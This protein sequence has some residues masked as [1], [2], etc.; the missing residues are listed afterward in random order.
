MSISILYITDQQ[1]LNDYIFNLRA[2]LQSIDE[3][4]QCK[5]VAV[6]TETTGL[7]PH[8]D[9]I[10]LIQLYVKGFS[11][12]LVIDCFKINNLSPV[13]SLLE[14]PSIKKIF[15]NAKFDLKF[16][17]SVGINVRGQLFDTMVAGQLLD[18]GIKRKN[19]LKELAKRYLNLELSK[20]ERKSDW[21]RA[22]LSP[23]QLQYSAKDVIILPSLRNTLCRELKEKDLVRV[24]SIEFDCIYAVAEMEYN[25][26]KMNLKGWRKLQK[27]YRGRKEVIKEDLYSELKRTSDLDIFGEVSV[28]L[29]SPSQMLT[30]FKKLNIPVPN[31]NYFTLMNFRSIPLIEKFMEYR[32]VTKALSS[33]LEPLPEQINSA[34]GRLHPSYWQLGSAAGR[35]SCS[36]PNLQQI[37][38]TSDFRSCFIPEPGN[39][40]VIADYSQIE[41]RVAAEISKDFTM[42]SAYKSNTDLHRLTASLVSGKHFEAVGKEERQLAKALNFGLLYG[43]GASGL[44]EYARNSYGVEMTLEQAEEFKSKFF[45]GYSGLAGWHKKVRRQQAST[46][47]TLAGRTRDFPEKE[48]FMLT[49]RLNTPVQGTAADILKIALGRLPGALRR[50]GA[51]IIGTVHDEVLLECAESKAEEV[52]EILQN[53]MEK[54]SFLQ[55]VPMEAEAKICKDWG[56]K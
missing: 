5:A 47:K 38:R 31:T 23:E 55:E 48:K 14:D 26:I 45:G 27:E 7:D 39:V 9:R 6:D 11:A 17:R 35:F 2:A 15:Q 30:L 3:T 53:T 46:V 21:S 49:T 10:R 40:L 33:F 1:N 16:L 18:C 4:K 13:K 36:S 34:T 12:V 32:K 24:A 56:G 43:M 28:N 54:A 8:K 22:E 51:Q 41:L 25:G 50:T 52:K 19:S 42:L 44:A 37:P 29:D 20:E